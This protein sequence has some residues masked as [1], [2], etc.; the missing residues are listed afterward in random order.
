MSFGFPRLV[1][2]DANGYAVIRFPDKHS[3]M[4]QIDHPRFATK[5]VTVECKHDL[6]EADYVIS[7]DLRGSAPNAAK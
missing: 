3:Y 4:V 7:L 1:R 5:I 2:S 6:A